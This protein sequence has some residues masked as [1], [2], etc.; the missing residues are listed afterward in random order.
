[1]IRLGNKSDVE[2]ILTI[3]KDAQGRLKQLNVNQWQDGYPNR[4]SIE[5][6]IENKQL[7][8]YLFNGEIVGTMTV[9][10]YEPTYDHVKWLNNKDYIVVHRI[11][12]KNNF[13]GKGIGK[14]LLLQ[15]M[16]LFKKDL[17]ID[18][19]PKNEPMQKML[20][21]LNFIYCGD[22]YIGPNDNDLRY[23]YQKEY[24]DD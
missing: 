12:I 14:K 21:S 1:M 9:L 16:A 23:C 4:K 15:A 18:T 13:N 3:I 2:A 5:T 19:H 7:Y 8:V 20:K 6:D 11:A 17:K 24:L 22:T 10:N